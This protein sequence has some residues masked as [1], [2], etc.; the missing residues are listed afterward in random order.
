MFYCDHVF[1]TRTRNIRV[2]NDF[3]TDI[4]QQIPGQKVRRRRRV[5]SEGKLGRRLGK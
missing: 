4:E 1:K 2:V 3:N 5:G